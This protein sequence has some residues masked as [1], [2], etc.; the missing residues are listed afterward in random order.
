MIWLHG[1][2]WISGAGSLDWYDGARLAREGGIVVVGVN[3]RLGALGF[4]CLPGV[5]EGNLGWLDQVA[6]LRWVQ[7]QYRRVRRRSGTH[8]AWPANP[9]A[10]HRSG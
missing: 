2:A 4:L 7:G 5:A 1:G 6:A 9:P 8:H 3:H 10:R